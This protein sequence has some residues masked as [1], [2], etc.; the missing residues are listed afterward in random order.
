MLCIIIITPVIQIL[1]VHLNCSAKLAHANQEILLLPVFLF[2]SI[3]HCINCMI[4]YSFFIIRWSKYINFRFCIENKS[5][6]NSVARQRNYISLSTAL[7]ICF[8]AGA[9][10]LTCS[11][12]VRAG[13]RLF[14]HS[15]V[16]SYN[17]DTSKENNAF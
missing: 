13:L 7:R 10:R 8:C 3:L 17:N 15:T 4:I 6:E 5:C 9:C 14:R 12:L 2:L 11:I 1:V 16:H